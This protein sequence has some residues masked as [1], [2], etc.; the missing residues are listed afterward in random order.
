MGLLLMINCTSIWIGLAVLWLATLAGCAGA[1]AQ[2]TPTVANTATSTFT[3]TA[4]ATATATPTRTPSP[5]NTATPTI[6]PTPTHT[7][8]ATPTPTRNLAGCNAA[9]CGSAAR[10]LPTVAY[11]PKMLL[12]RKT[13]QRRL[14]PECPPNERMSEKELNALVKADPGTLNQLLGIALSQQA[15]QL[16]PGVVYIVA[17]AVHYVVIDLKE[18]GYVLRN[19][20]PPVP[21]LETEANVRI[22]PSYCFRPESLVVMTADY[23]GL[24]S[25]NKTENGWELFFHMGRA[26]L[27]ERD[28]RFDID[29]IRKHDEFAQTTVSWGAGPIFMWDGQFDYNPKQE[30][31]TPENLFHYRDTRWGKTIAAL[32]DD[33][34]YLFLSVTYGITLKEYSQKLI[35]LAGKWGIKIDRAM[36]FDGNENTYMAIRL[37]DHMVPLL[38]IEEPLIVNCLAVE[39][40]K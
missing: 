22:T 1:T 11:S 23:H 14:C 19:I 25:S 34:R 38:G 6:T 7:A 4:T 37:N 3:A 31:F 32:S 26:A 30:W 29:V 18:S 35:D 40:P 33:R 36:I 5:T 12:T 8:T 15:H 39:R 24:V 13:P 16:A 2:P 27:F 21:D 20:I 10:P 9:G 17:D 28:G